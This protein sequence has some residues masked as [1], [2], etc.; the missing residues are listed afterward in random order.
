MEHASKALE[1]ACDG[2]LAEP[3]TVG[4]ARDVSFFRQDGKED[5]QIQI[6]LAQLRDTHSDYEHYVLDA[7]KRKEHSDSRPRHPAFR[8]LGVR[9]EGGITEAGDRRCAGTSRTSAAGDLA[10]RET[11]P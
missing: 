2:W 6:S 10:A 11:E 7:V 1:R 3:K 4:C 9:L 8:G 5:K